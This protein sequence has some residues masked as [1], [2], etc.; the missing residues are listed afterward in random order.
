MATLTVRNLPDE[1]R[2]ALRVRAAQRGRSMEAEARAI[3]VASLEWKGAG[4]YQPGLGDGVT[5]YEGPSPAR[6][7]RAVASLRRMS[8]QIGQGKPPRWSIVDEFLAEKHLEGAWENGF[9]TTE[10]RRHWLDRL[11]SYAVLPAE[12]EAF[13]ASRLRSE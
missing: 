8:E 10:E 7:A 11:E 1:V 3:L 12:L 6:R 5:A 4:S 13:V 2:D 9:V